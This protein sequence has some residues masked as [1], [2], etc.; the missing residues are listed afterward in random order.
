MLPKQQR[1]CEQ[2]MRH[3][4]ARGACIR[5]RDVTIRYI[6]ADTHKCGVVVGKKGGVTAVER[7]RARRMVYDMCGDMMTT[8]PPLHI[9]VML[10]LRHGEKVPVADVRDCYQQLEQREKMR[11][12]N[13]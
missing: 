5:S 12:T 4:L 11:Y 2:E 10:R 3:V 13:K 8:L 1:L 9:A 6:A 7:N